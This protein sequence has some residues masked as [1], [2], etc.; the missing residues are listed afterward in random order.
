[1][2]NLVSPLLTLKGSIINLETL[3]AHHLPGLEV[4]ARPKEIWKHYALDASKP[5]TFQR[6]F[7]RASMEMEA[8]KEHC[9][10]IVDRA[11]QRVIGS[12][13]FLNIEPAHRKLEIGWTWLHPDYWG[14]A[15]NFECKLLLLTHCFEQLNIARVQ[16]KTDELNTRSRRAIEKLDATYE[17]ILRNDMV[18]E[19]GSH[20]NSAY[21]SIIIQEWPGIKELLVQNL[22]SF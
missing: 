20:R 18:R 1:M 3:Q 9:F 11:D 12:T 22:S 2:Q 13:R 21:Y 14:T 16:V 7:Q 17:G 5:T 4:A 6:A 19:D 8:G 15:V 10:V